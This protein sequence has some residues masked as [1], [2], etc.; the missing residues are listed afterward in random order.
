[1]P[2]TYPWQ[3]DLNIDAIL[4]AMQD[5]G[6]VVLPT[7]STYEIAASSLHPGAVTRLQSLRDHGLHAAI[8]ITEDASLRDWL[9][10]LR[11]AGWRLFR[12]LGPGPLVLRA[13]GGYAFGLTAQLPAVAQNWLIQDHCLAVRWPAH[14][15]WPDLCQ[16][17]LPIFSVCLPNAHTAKEAQAQIGEMAAYIVDAGATE[18]GTLPS[19]VRAEGRQ[20]RIEREGVLT[21]EQIAELS[22]CRIV[23]ICTGNT[24]R[25]P[26]AEVLCAKLLAE[27]FGCSVD[28]LHEH[29]FCVQSAG[30]AAMMGQPASPEAVDVVANFGAD[31][32]GHRS[33][34]VTMEMLAWADH[35]FTMT[36]GHWHSLNGIPVAG[37]PSPRMLSPWREDVSDP[38][39]GE[40]ADYQA[41]A[42][43]I[44]LLLK[45]RLPELL[46]S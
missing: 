44:L 12:K 5:G 19:V 20:Y 9:P 34:M 32:S 4:Q 11:G 26:M 22:A 1:M 21:A 42:E 14:P 13:N 15:I 45:E 24:C 39:G 43:Q 46:E 8:A 3:P 36:H 38:I 17:G 30:I 31:L 28:Q 37:L 33:Q 41:C 35:V 23:F 40:L 16:R 6:C 18:F 27:Q 29:G 7:E 25:S 2:L 10:W